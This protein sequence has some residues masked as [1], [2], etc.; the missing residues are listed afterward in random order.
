MDHDIELTLDVVAAPQHGELVP[1]RSVD[2]RHAM[3]RTPSSMERTPPHIVAGSEDAADPV[4]IVV[5]APQPLDGARRRSSTG[6]SRS[7]L[8]AMPQSRSSGRQLPR[9]YV[10]RRRS[11]P[12]GI[13]QSTVR[14]QIDLM[15]PFKEER[16][17]PRWAW[18][19]GAGAIIVTAAA[20]LLR[21]L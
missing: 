13:R 16:A 15:G 4:G 7:V 18:L 12:K 19:A 11:S 14:R 21:M 10:A 20:L 5:A 8:G 1:T 9:A 2:H 17:V 6:A 3:P